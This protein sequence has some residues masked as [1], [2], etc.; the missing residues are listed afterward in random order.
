MREIRFRAWDKN[1]KRMVDWES[2]IN[3][4][5]DGRF[6]GITGYDPLNNDPLLIPMQFTGLYDRQGKEI[7]EGDVVRYTEHPG[8]IMKSFVSPIL[9][10]VDKAC[11]CYHDG[12]FERPFSEADELRTDVL[13]H[14][15]VIGNI[16][17]KK[18]E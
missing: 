13:D 14:M 16:Y 3:N 18:S 2:L 7:W 11:F 15:E 12:D 6:E 10:N 17:E 4:L 1:L 5:M 9:W 8:Y